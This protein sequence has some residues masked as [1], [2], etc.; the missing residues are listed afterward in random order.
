[1][2]NPL[3]TLDGESFEWTKF[4]E[5]FGYDSYWMGPVFKEQV[6]AG[7]YEIIVTSRN[8]DSKY[9]LAV[10]EAELF[11][12]KETMNAMRLVPQIKQDFFNESPIGF[13]LSPMGAGFVL[14]M[15][16]LGFLFGFFYRFILRRFTRNK[17]R[18]TSQNINLNGRL[19]RALIGVLLLIWGITTSWNPLIFFFAGF[20]LF[21]AIFSWCGLFAALGKS[22]CPLE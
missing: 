15:L 9:S 20:V 22:S 1:L 19:L 5:P 12:F 8:N 21:E 17:I 3:A 7:N 2:E 6:P 18:K 4:F 11:D 10:G 16:T 13:I 14:I